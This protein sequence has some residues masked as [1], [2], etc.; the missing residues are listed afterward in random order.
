MEVGDKV[1]APFAINDKQV[2]LSA[3]VVA[4]ITDFVALGESRAYAYVAVSDDQ[5]ID[6]HYENCIRAGRKPIAAYVDEAI[7][8]CGL[9]P[10]ITKSEARIRMQLALQAFAEDYDVG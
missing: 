7:P 10:T 8:F 3:R 2:Q 6:W 5:L 4:D 1:V 9:S